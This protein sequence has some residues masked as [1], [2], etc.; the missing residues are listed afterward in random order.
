MMMT[1]FESMVAGC[2]RFLDAKREVSMYCIEPVIARRGIF[3]GCGV[4][5]C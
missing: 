5:V 3:C 4:F 1:G 2:L